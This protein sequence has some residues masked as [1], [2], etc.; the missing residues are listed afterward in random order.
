MQIFQIALGGGEPLTYPN[1]H[2]AIEKIARCGMASSITTSGLGLDASVLEELV[3][4]GLNH[5]QISLNG[6][7]EKVNSKSRDGY[8]CAVR[9]LELLS[10]YNISF[11]VNWVARRD[12][13][14]D[15]QNFIEKM[16]GYNVG[17]INILR[18]KPSPNEIYEDNCLSA[19]K[20]SLLAGIL[21]NTRGITLKVDSA[22]SNLLCHINQR[23]SFMS[24]C[25]AG[26]RFLAIDAEGFFRP[27]SHVSMKEECNNL[28]QVWHHSEHLG[29]FREISERVEKPCANCKYLHGCFGCRAVVLGR[30]GYFFD[31]DIGCLCCT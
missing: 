24:G 14:D 10:G 25:G 27:C 9:A 23:T 28:Y 8:E 20:M 13:I 11:G 30:G 6:S 19:D 7:C 15:F 26:R 5:I 21:K 12:N 22:F 4:C 16:K 3:R 29:M 2:L 1:I 18:Y 17:N 31:G